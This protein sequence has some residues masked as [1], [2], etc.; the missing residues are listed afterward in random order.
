MLGRDGSDEGVVHGAT[1]DPQR[2]ELLREHRGSI[3]SEVARLGEVGTEDP[4]DEV[5]RPPCRRRE[6]REHRE[7]LER[8]VS[9]ETEPASAELSGGLD[10]VLV[11]LEDECDRDAGVD[12]REFCLSAGRHR[13][14]PG[15]ARPSRRC[16]S[17]RDHEKAGSRFVEP[18]LRDWLD[19][20]RGAVGDHLDG[21]RLEAEVVAKRLRDDEPPCSSMVVLIPS[22]YHF[23]GTDVAVDP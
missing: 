16:P 17:E 9:S 15:P 2:T 22:C 13:A 6:S 10:V 21:T 8:R 12:E 5:P 11:I 14:T 1:G 20:K 4:G 23:S 18:L 19:A 3:G 7:G